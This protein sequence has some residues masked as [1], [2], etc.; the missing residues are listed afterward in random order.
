MRYQVVV[1]YPDRVRVKGRFRKRKTTVMRNVVSTDD[2]QAAITAALDW[3]LSPSDQVWVMDR[4][5]S[6][7][8]KH[9]GRP[10]LIRRGW[11]S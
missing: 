4:G 8:S 1:H 6:S 10:I 2:R 7:D 5:E 9:S 11:L 3:R